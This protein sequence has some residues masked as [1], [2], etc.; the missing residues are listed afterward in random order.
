MN[1]AVSRFHHNP[2]LSP[3]ADQPWEAKAVFNPSLVLVNGVFHLVYRAMGADQDYEGRHL[4][5]STI[6]HA[7][8]PDGIT[9]TDRKQIIRPDQEWDMYGCEDPRLTWIDN[10]YIVLYTAL[11]AYPP[12]PNGIRVGVALGPDLDHLTEKHLV[13]PF[14]AK[15]M[16]LFPEKVN[17]RYCVLVTVNTDRPPARVGLAYFD[18]LYQ[19]WSEVF[20]EDWYYS[21]DQHE[22]W[23]QRLNTDQ[24]EVGAV[25]IKTGHG[26]LFFYAHIQNYYTP[27]SRIF[28]IEA[29]LLD[30]D[31]PKNIISR[32]D[33]PLLAPQMSYEVTGQIANVVF[34]SG[35]T[36]TN[37]QLFLYY[38]AADTYCCAAEID[39][40]VLQKELADNPVKKAFSLTKYLLNPIL[41]PNTQN[42]FETQAV[43]N[44]AA[45]YHKKQF[46]LIYR[47]LS[48]DNTSS[49]GLAVSQDGFHFKRFDEPIYYPTKEFEQKK[50]ANQLSGCEDPRLTQI[51]K[52]L[53]LFYT[54]FD[55]Q[56]PPRVAMTS[57]LVK[58]FVHYRWNWADP[59]LISPP[60]ADDKNTCLLPE[61]INDRFVIF[62]RVRGHDIA[63]DFVEDLTFTS[64]QWLEKE[65]A[66]SPR[67]G[68]WDSLKI[69][70]SS[71]PVKTSE[72]WLLLYHGVSE[73]DFQYRIGYMILDINNPAKVLYRSRYPIL[74]PTEFF[75]KQGITPNVVFPCGAVVVHGTL[76]VYY[77]CAD[78]SIGVATAQLK[79]FLRTKS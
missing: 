64:R 10:Q 35:A 12:Q 21:L 52:T 36:M 1:P 7:V 72:G 43:F 60:G 47:A 15:A 59:I 28:G 71:P 74:Q 67:P 78:Q 6:G 34:P 37:N 19:L 39:W 51:G 41:Q 25:P 29:A 16:V 27:A 44:P 22:L 76:F 49:L 30:E 45:W 56:N 4:S 2:V 14:N 54:A 31:D 48:N 26:W 69:G 18:H 75:E 33:Q 79:D 11:S 66:I 57:I 53:F 24:V 63:I 3:L 73:I 46:Y 9:F 50:S 8:S 62:H 38:G 68:W 20:W 40:P 61:K 55:G 42:A 58:D 32:T 65:A 77:G 23:L 13:T 17:G 5:L 70:I